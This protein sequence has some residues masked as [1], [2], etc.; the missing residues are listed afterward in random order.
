MSEEVQWPLKGDDI[1]AKGDRCL[2][3]GSEPVEQ[4][5]FTM[6]FACGSYGQFGVPQGD[7]M[8]EVTLDCAWRA[9]DIIAALQQQ[10]NDERRAKERIIDMAIKREL[11][12]CD[13]SV[14]DDAE[15]PRC[16]GKDAFVDFL[17]ALKGAQP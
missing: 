16:M 15:C 5:G 6:K 14:T 13:T 1:L 7:Y 10:L 9:G 2:L 4:T 8:D 17:T 12:E 3:C 11:G